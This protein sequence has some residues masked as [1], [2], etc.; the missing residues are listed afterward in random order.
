MKNHDQWSSFI[1]FIIGLVISLYSLKYGLGTFSNPGPG[2][3]PFLAGLALGSLSLVVFFQQFSKAGGGRI[4]ELWTQR[5][6]PTMIMVMAALILYTILFRYVGF[7][8]DTFLLTAFLFRAMEPMSWKKVLAG[9]V[10]TALGSYLIF[11]LWLQA[12]L[13]SGFLGF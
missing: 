12:Q 11:E 8:V 7:I 2:F 1:W 9:S 3:V 6:W 13:P 5:N 4:R 10:S